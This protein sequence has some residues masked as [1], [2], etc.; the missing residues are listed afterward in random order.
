MQ[1]FYPLMH[2]RTKLPNHGPVGG[3][4]HVE[5]EEAGVMHVVTPC[6]LWAGGALQ[7]RPHVS[8]SEAEVSTHSCE[9]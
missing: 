3:T 2:V 7:G 1:G 4:R 9:T 8:R 5:E 6:S